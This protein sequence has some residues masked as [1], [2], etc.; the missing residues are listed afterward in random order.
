MLV[1]I[2]TTEAIRMVASLR[3]HAEACGI[4]LGDRLTG[5]M[6]QDLRREMRALNRWADTIDAQVKTWLRR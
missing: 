5:R 6:R 1:S 2:R 4:M 3:R